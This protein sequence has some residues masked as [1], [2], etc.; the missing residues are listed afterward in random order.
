MTNTLEKLKINVRD[1]HGQIN[2]TRLKHIKKHITGSV[3]D[4]GCARGGYVKYFRNLGYEID[5]VD[6]ISFEKD[7]QKIGIEKYCKKINPNFEI[8]KTYD[9]VL[10]FEVLEHIPNPT[11]YLKRIKPSVGKKII[12]TVP[13]CKQTDILSNGGLN[14]NHYTDSSHVNF[15]TKESLTKTLE[16]AG[17]KT[18]HYTKF[19][20]INAFYVIFRQFGLNHKISK[21]LAKINVIL[22]KKLFYTQLIIA[23]A[24]K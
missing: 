16:N 15:F 8:E 2:S 22:P 10:L 7:W 9:T 13:D 1:H 5:G 19:N 18:T 6:L 21:M 17:Y 14:F 24:Q 4:I 3:L 11:E 12:I 23:N 20:Y